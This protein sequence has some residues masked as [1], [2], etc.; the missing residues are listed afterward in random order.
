MARSKIASLLDGFSAGYGLVGQV[1]K[2][3]ELRQVAEAAPEVNQG[4]LPEPDP[5]ALQANR[6]L[7][8]GPPGSDAYPEPQRTV[9]ASGGVR[10]PSTYSLLGQTQ[11]QPFTPEQASKARQLAQ[12]GVLDKFGDIEGAGRIRDRLQRADLTDLQMTGEKARQGREATQF[13]WAQKDRAKQEEWSAERKRLQQDGLIGQKQAA[14]EK[15][16]NNYQ[17]AKTDY[18]KKVADGDSAAVQPVMPSKPVI[19]PW[20]F[21]VDHAK[22]LANDYAHE[23]ASTKDLFEFQRMQ[24]QMEQEGMTRGLRAL[25]DG[26]SVAQVVALFNKSG[27]MQ[28]DPASVVDRGFVK[29]P[30]GMKTRQIEIK[31]PDGSTTPIDSMAGLQAF[32]EAGDFT[33]NFFQLRQLANSDKQVAIAGG[34]LALAA[35]HS[36]REQ[37]AFDTAEPERQ[38]KANI[39]LLKTRISE[40][41]EDSPTYKQDLALLSG[42]LQAE[43]TG[44]RG[45]GANV[46][47]AHQKDARA[48]VALGNYPD[49]GKALDA[50]MNKP[51]QLHK[52][53]IAN[54]MK[55]NPDLDAAIT[56]ADNGMVRMGWQRDGTSWFRVGKARAPGAGQTV[57]KGSVVRGTDGMYEYLGGDKSDP[58]SWKKK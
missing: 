54:A 3:R 39:A 2:D 50:V 46:D 51:D 21:L 10:A 11:E 20:E 36:K 43:M 55:L 48:L 37:E 56:A 41:K 40:L 52:E 19:L 18:D 14:Y 16:M 13:D 44:T 42:K 29:R 8:S 7:A 15:A 57:V 34:H 27:Q 22:L 31:N 53:L 32:K 5:K 9:D 25:Q 1:M 28:I 35:Q 45:I 6:D 26:A 12:A 30:D 33:H 4:A 47:T 58:K 23:K 38:A 17:T 49:E 24:D